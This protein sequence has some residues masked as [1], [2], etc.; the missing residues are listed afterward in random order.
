MLLP[1][2]AQPFV[3]LAILLVSSCQV[4]SIPTEASTCTEDGCWFTQLSAA[5][6][7]SASYDDSVS[8]LQL[9]ASAESSTRCS[10]YAGHQHGY[11]ECGSNVPFCGVLTL[12]LGT[13]GGVYQHTEP[14]VHGLWPQV[15]GDK[16]CYGDSKC[17]APRDTSKPAVLYPC[18]EATDGS[19]K[20]QDQQLWFEQHEWSSHGMC[21]GVQD[22]A[23]FFTQVCSLAGKTSREDWSGPLKVMKAARVAGMD[24]TETANQLQ[25][26]GYCVW[27]TSTHSQI[28]LSACAGDDGIWKLADHSEFQSKCASKATRPETT[29]TTP[30]ASGS[31][32]RGQHGPPCQADSDCAG[33]TNCLRCARSGFCT[34][35]PLS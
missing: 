10:P 28:E 11:M 30:S 31:C 5:T 2:G 13:G 32:V 33:V 27:T 21:A 8:L 26:S 17:R 16:S 29:S 3:C 25:R 24:I 6:E 22:A 9:R 20:E 14:T 12:E 15:C 19:S 34:D 23:D 7:G 35:V 1:C 4:W 18:Y